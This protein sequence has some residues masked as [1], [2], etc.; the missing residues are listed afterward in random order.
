[1]SSQSGTSA[2]PGKGLSRTRSGMGTRFPMRTCA[3]QG[4]ESESRF[5]PRGM[6]SSARYKLLGAVVALG[7]MLGGCSDIYFDR[8][9]TIALGADD[10]IAANRVAQM[11][12]PWPRYVGNKNIAFNG[13]RMQGAVER[14]R[15]HEVIRPVPLTT[16]TY[17]QQSPPAPITTEHI[18]IPRAV[19]PGAAAPVANATR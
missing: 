8:R 7:A 4:S 12:D 15:R 6:R 19:A 18:S 10:H 16:N 13:E 9:E 3:K 5:D 17:S 11:V 2:C 14:Y 1:M